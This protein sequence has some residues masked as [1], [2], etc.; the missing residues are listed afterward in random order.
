MD[1]DSL[2]NSSRFVIPFRDWKIRGKLIGVTLFLVLFPLLLVVYLSLAH[3]ND[4]LKK[5]SEEDMEHLV[6]SVYLLCK[7]QQEMNPNK[8]VSI[9][10]NG[11][12]IRSRQGS[13]R[14][15]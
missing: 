10:D 2:K 9:P 15:T 13:D 7:A 6:R 14:S 5:A 11:K 1:Q 8:A 4:A 12:R 3:F